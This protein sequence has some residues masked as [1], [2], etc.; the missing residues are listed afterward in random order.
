MKDI[1]KVYHMLEDE[2][3]RESYLNFLDYVISRDYKY[4]KN[5]VSAYMPGVPPMNGKTVED[6]IDSL[7]RDRD[8]VL[9]GASSFVCQSISLWRNCERFIG[10]CS[11]TKSKQRDGY[12]GYPVMSPEELLRRR[13]LTVVVYAVTARDEIMEILRAGKYPEEQI[14]D[15]T[16]YIG[17]SDPYQYFNL[18]VMKFDDQEVFV[19]AGCYNLVTTLTLKKV[20]HRQTNKQLK[21]VYALEPDPYNCQICRERKDEMHLDEVEIFPYGTW[22]ERT[23]LHFRSGE[24][25]SS[26]ICEDGE[27]VVPV[28]PIDDVV[29]PS[30]PVT[31]IKM[32]VEGAELES[33]KGARRTIQRDRPKLA[34]CIYHKPEDLTE[35]PLYLKEL[36]P[37]Y[38]FYV[39]LHATNGNEFVLYAIPPE[40][41]LQDT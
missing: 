30:E 11:G 16:P 22:S 1:D 32:D 7:P 41:A 35:I 8:I 28:C 9:Y 5:I 27:S 3:S 31:M 25:P 19:D 21:K 4:I 6:L 24:L 39:R 2:E 34:I 38:K 18:N 14:Y 10:F 37:E 26:C 33:L 17:W 29:D 40:H 20:L 36:V 12:L 23:Q 13:D 15:A